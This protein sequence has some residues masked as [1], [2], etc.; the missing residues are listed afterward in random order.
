MIINKKMNYNNSTTT[1]ATLSDQL[2]ELLIN[3]IPDAVT[4]TLSDTQN[5]VMELVDQNKNVLVLGSAGCGKSTI[6]KEIKKKYHDLNVHITSTTGIS[7]YNIQGITLHSYMGFGT[8]EQSIRTLYTRMKRNVTCIDR[9][10]ETDILVV[11]EI[12]M[13]SAEL[14][15]KI[16][17]LLRIVRNNN[18]PF[19]GI[20]VIF[21]GDLLQLK[22]VIKVTEFNPNPDERLIFESD[23]FLKYFKHNIVVLTTNFRQENDKLY[24][25]ILT[26]IR[27]NKSTELDLEE[28]KKCLNRDAPSDVPFLVSTNKMASHIN[29]KEM[30]KLKSTSYK[31]VAIFKKHVVASNSL[32]T[33][34]MYYNELKNQFKQKGLEELVLKVGCRVM[35][36]RN[37]DVSSGLVNGALGTVEI[38]GNNFVYVQFDNGCRQE[39]IKEKCELGDESCN[40]TAYQIPLILA[41]S[42]TI[43]KSQSLT[44]EK[45]RID[46]ASCFADHMVYVALSRVKSLDGL[47]LESFSHKKITVD[48]K[49]IEFLDSI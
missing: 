44:L 6:I 34:D 24:Q 28:L 40:A 47:Y 2:R 4:N 38:T 49:T 36:T 46:L 45:A 16:D 19:G 9:I 37:L 1:T 29:N 20:R 13:L 22:P 12:S 33:C 32:E 17:S 27:F 5:K 23:S 7:A 10:K 18:C 42:V 41:Y 8:G 35:L 25:S 31:Y 48:K 43:H 14:F 39:I 21:S 15:E 11:D 26:N 3:I 30:N